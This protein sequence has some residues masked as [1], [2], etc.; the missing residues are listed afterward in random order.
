MRLNSK[1][2]Y[3]FAMLLM[4]VACEESPF[5]TRKEAEKEIAAINLQRNPFHA[6]ENVVAI[7]DNDIYYFH[8]LDEEPVRLTTT[9]GEEK[10]N[11]KLS[12]DK[13]RIAYLNGSGTPVIIRADNGEHVETLDE[14]AYVTQMD[15]AKDRLTLYILVESEVVFYGDAIDVVQP[16]KVNSWDRVISFSMN[17][18]GDQ[19]YFIEYSADAFPHWLN[20]RSEKGGIADEFSG[21]DG[22]NFDYIDFYDNSGGFLLGYEDYHDG[23]ME[24][25]ICVQNYT[26]Y[27]TYK[28][29]YENMNTPAFNSEHEMLLY[30]TVEGTGNHMIKA[31][32]L[33]EKWYEGHGLYDKLTY[34]LENH[35][36]ASP[37]F[38]DWVQ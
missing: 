31:V 18:I 22:D 30:G 26:T 36:S 35:P 13:S 8:A 7:L 6:I 9:P 32:Y 38:I 2:L 28:W 4:L 27:A 5:V 12:F 33:G 3:W 1:K 25:I 20:L 23:S 11:V 17:S 16:T 14:Y 34:V 15:W 24:R 37:I 19:G 29:D 10:T 21:W